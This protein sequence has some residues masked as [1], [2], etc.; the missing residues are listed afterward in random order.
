MTPKPL[1]GSVT[2]KTILCLPLILPSHA[3]SAGSGDAVSAES[4]DGT[5]PLNPTAA[6]AA[7]IR[8]RK[9]RRAV[10]EVMILDMGAPSAMNGCHHQSTARREVRK[11][12]L[13]LSLI[14]I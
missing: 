14:H 9:P 12:S 11:G 2:S 7:A 8:P 6:A 1:L 10:V 3:S 13:T 4:V 5:P